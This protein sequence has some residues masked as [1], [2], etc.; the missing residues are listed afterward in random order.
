[1]RKIKLGSSQLQVP[2][3]GIG[4]MRIMDLSPKELEQFISSSVDQGANF[5]DHADVYKD[6][7]CEKVFGQ[8]VG[9]LKIAREKMILQSKCGIVRGREFNFSKEHI[10]KATEASLKRLNTDYLDVLL[11]HRPDALFEPEQVAAAFDELAAS[12]K[13][14]HF[15]VSNQ[16]PMQ[17]KLLQKFVKQPLIVN[18]LQLNIVNASMISEG[19]H[20]N[21]VYDDRSINH[22]GSILNFCRIE[23]ITIQT[24]SPFQ[25]AKDKLFQ[26]T[27]ID[28]PDFPELND[29]LA[30]V[31]KA[32]NVSKTTI[33]MAWL[34]KHPA[35]FQPIT[36]TTKTTRLSECFKATEINL[37]HTQWYEIYLSAGNILP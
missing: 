23:D 25:Y 33:A 36:G 14:R 21:Q 30:E 20:V 13:V 12:G 5:F 3:I 29:K 26:G 8:A 34:L 11:L 28:N 10:L 4:C 16:N 27:F 9:S 35:K 1:M 2:V 17:I 31:A 6:G 19:L 15:G 24:W 7:E 22:D 32:Y 37:T 18:Q